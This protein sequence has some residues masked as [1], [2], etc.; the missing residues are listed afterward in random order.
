MIVWYTEVHGSFRCFGCCSPHNVGSHCVLFQA[1]HFCLPLCDLLLEHYA[2]NK[3]IGNLEQNML[4]CLAYMFSQILLQLLVLIVI[5]VL[6][7]LDT[8]QRVATN[9]RTY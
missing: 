1:L 3:N 4:T 8:L 7:F 2:N 5:P 6:N 9:N